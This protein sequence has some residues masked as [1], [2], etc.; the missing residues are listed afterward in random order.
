MKQFAPILVPILIAEASAQVVKPPNFDPE[1]KWQI[2]IQSTIDP[3]APLTPTDALV[4]DLDLYHV[5]RH[6]EVV[7]YLR[8]NIPGVNIICYF[9]AG[10]VQDSDCDWDDWQRPEYIG[11]LGEYYESDP[12]TGERWVNIRNQ[13]GIDRIKRRVR[14]AAQLG[15]DGVDPD[16]IDG[17]NDNTGFDLN[18]ADYINFVTQLADQA[19]ALTT[20]RSFTLLIGQKNAAELV[21][22]LQPVL[23]FAVLEDCKNLLGEAERAFCADFQPYI[24]N[25][26]Q[27]KP[28][29]S[30]EYP[31]TLRDPAA[32][33]QCRTT[34]ADEAQYE[35][36]CANDTVPDGPLGNYR[37]SE[38]LKLRDEGDEATELNGCTQYCVPEGQ[39]PASGVVVTAINSELEGDDC[40]ATGI[41]SLGLK[42]R[43]LQFFSA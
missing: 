31:T 40:T 33:Q 7:T 10:L 6:P 14:L 21:P 29:F 25:T 22:D 17:Y 30:I 5:S 16:N 4:W 35:A 26:T 24:A 23:D 38:I 15:C 36:S 43:F 13:T 42:T 2:E 37:Y 20:N 34:G 19:H 27:T 39:D 41:E 12:N 11:L 18:S 9:N 8:D 32:P 1:V 3:M 28:V